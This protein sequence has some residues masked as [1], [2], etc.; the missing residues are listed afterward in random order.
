MTGWRTNLK[1]NK[2]LSYHKI[3]FLGKELFVRID[4]FLNTKITNCLNR[5]I[6]NTHMKNVKEITKYKWWRE[7]DRGVRWMYHTY[8]DEEQSLYCSSVGGTTYLNKHY[9]TAHYE[10][11]IGKDMQRSK[12]KQSESLAHYLP[13]RTQGNSRKLH[14]RLQ[15]SEPRFSSWT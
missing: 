5:N 13:T 6:T 10:S 3:L 7:L 12:W 9:S 14:S 11:W 4:L 8:L 1:Y 2:L 15:F